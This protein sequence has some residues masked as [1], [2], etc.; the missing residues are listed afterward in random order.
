MDELERKVLML[1]SRGLTKNK[2]THIGSMDA[3]DFNRVW[4][5]WGLHCWK[6]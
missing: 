1:L 3:P 4:R 2:D 5:G 6:A